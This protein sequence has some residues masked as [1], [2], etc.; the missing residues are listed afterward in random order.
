MY[1]QSFSE[2]P[3]QLGMFILS[4]IPAN[5]LLWTFSMENFNLGIAKM[6]VILENPV[7]KNPVIL[8]TSVSC[9]SITHYT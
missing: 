7:F 3:D 5:T 9:L 4:L 2:V 6:F 1:V 8:K